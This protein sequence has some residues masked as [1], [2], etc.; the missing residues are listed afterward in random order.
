LLGLQ[1]ATLLD[2]FIVCMSYL[3]ARDTTECAAREEGLLNTTAAG[4]I[5]L[6][7]DYYNMLERMTCKNITMR[8]DCWPEKYCLL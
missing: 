6:V 7:R 8:H 1:T 5:H 4:I 3:R 2:L